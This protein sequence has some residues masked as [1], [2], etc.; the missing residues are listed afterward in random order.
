MTSVPWYKKVEGKNRKKRRH[1]IARNYVISIRINLETEQN[2]KC[3]SIFPVHWFF[4][5]TVIWS[6]D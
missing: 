6:L 2:N 4:D 3:V 1:S 5:K